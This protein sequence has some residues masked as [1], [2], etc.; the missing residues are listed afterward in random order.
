MT[1]GRSQNAPLA[2]VS[3][4]KQLIESLLLFALKINTGAH[5]SQGP[6]PGHTGSISQAEIS[7]LFQLRRSS[8]AQGREDSVCGKQ[9]G[10]DDTDCP[11]YGPSGLLELFG[12]FWREEI[13]E[14]TAKQ[15]KDGRTSRVDPPVQVQ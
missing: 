5:Q 3:A 12:P 7:A 9:Q 4:V 6:V 15:C 11:P 10:Q 13:D 1:A 14:P 2:A 8:A